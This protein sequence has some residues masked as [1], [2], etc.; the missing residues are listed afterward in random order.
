M[1]IECVVVHQ[2]GFR[3]THQWFVGEIQAV[4]IDDDYGR[5]QPLMFWSGEYRK[6]GEF[7]ERAW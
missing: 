1:N 3:G 2:I 4:H 5:D 6:V 7:L